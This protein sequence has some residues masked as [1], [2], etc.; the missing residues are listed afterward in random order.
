MTSLIFL[1]DPNTANRPW[2][3]AVAALL[4]ISTAVALFFLYRN[5]I[6]HFKQNKLER[7]SLT[8]EKLND[9]SM[10]DKLTSSVSV[11]HLLAQINED[12][13]SIDEGDL[14]LFF[15]M[16][17]DNFRYIVD[18][19]SQ[20]DVDKIIAEYSKRLKKY[21]A[22]GSI[23][24]HYEKDIFI[25]YYKGVLDNDKI[26]LIAQELLDL[27]KQPTKLGNH[28][29][30][31]S[32]GICLFPYDGITASRLL[33]NAEVAV[34]VAKKEGKNRFCMYS[35][36]MIESEQFNVEYY[37]QIKRSIEKN[38]FLLYYQ[39]M[40]DI[41]T[42]RIIG[43]ESLLRWQHPTMGILPPSKFLN[44]MDLTGDITWFGIWGFEKV[45]E[46]YAKWKKNIKL[47]DFFISINLSPKQLNVQD[48]ARQYYEITNKNG[49][50]PENFCLEI[51][52]YYIV[53]H[54]E[55]ALNNL[56]EFRRYGFRMAID[57]TGPNFAII[58]DM[59][60]VSA[61]IFK[62]S[63]GHLLQITGDDPDKEKIEKVITEAKAN[64]KIVIAEGI[65]DEDT[66]RLLNRMDIRFMQGYFFS[67][68]ISVEDAGRMIHRSPWDMFSFNHLIK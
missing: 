27:F 43:M 13:N 21:A 33:K 67:E 26:N 42:G 57:D 39:P 10:L 6:F 8:K 55:I 51:L 14:R 40:V 16:N 38:E 18:S 65:E 58:D 53:T 54:N 29:L 68:P 11:N 34:Y 32:I 1:T 62:L 66:I 59:S 17:L 25:Y 31:A 56:K 3:V 47:G 5:V 37:K 20:K 44:V 36:G 24:G 45:A 30:S 49:L 23:A 63:R 61:S 48:L 19:Y 60:K 41:R 64:Q 7:D 9:D 22:K 28:Q 50:N 52:D 12:I 2:E 46:R 15:A 35:Q 4:V